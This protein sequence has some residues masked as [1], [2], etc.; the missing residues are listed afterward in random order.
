MNIITA[1]I[2]NEIPCGN[3]AIIMEV[4]AINNEISNNTIMRFP[5]KKQ[6]LMIPQDTLPNE[7]P[8]SAIPN[9]TP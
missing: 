2:K 7:P 4:I 5:L 9:K 1:T 6:S 3:N 8:N